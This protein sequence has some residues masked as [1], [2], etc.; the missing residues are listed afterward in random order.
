MYKTQQQYAFILPVA[1][2]LQCHQIGIIMA[3]GFYFTGT[4]FKWVSGTSAFLCGC[5]P[6][7]FI[8]PGQFFPDHTEYFIRL[9]GIKVLML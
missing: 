6:G 9:P 3:T 8:N 4:K 2:P 5:F 1:C 7:H